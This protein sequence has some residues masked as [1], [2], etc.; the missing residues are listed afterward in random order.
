MAKS[1]PSEAAVAVTPAESDVQ[2]GDPVRESA[3]AA[4]AKA[5][6][7][8]NT[9]ALASAAVD[10]P[11]DNNAEVEA[12]IAAVKA[13]CAE[14]KRQTLVKGDRIK[15]IVRR[16]GLLTVAED[17]APD[18]ALVCSDKKQGSVALWRVVQSG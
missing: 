1:S 9:A 15:I 8:R 5:N 7:S 3:E 11:E 14:A 13:V 18:G 6:Q 10:I 16:E 12:E 17:F 2:T 4:V